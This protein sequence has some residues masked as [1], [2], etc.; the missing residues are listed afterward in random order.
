MTKRLR[1]GPILNVDAPKS[2]RANERDI[3]SLERMMALYRCYFFDGQSHVAAV[4]VVDRDDDEAALR[5]ARLLNESRKYS[6]TEVW[7]KGRL[8]ARTERVLST[9]I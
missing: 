2:H 4:E 1:F 7:D 8:V 6:H 3:P 9:S 5:A